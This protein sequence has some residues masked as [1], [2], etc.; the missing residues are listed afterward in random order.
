MLLRTVSLNRM[1]SWVTLPISLRSES[2]LRS[3]TSWPSTSRRPPVTSKKRGMRFTRVVLPAPL[4][5]TNATTSPRGTTRLMPRQDFFLALFR[6]RRR[7]AHSRSGSRCGIPS[8]PSRAAGRA[9]SSCSSMNSKDVA[10]RAQRLLEAVVEERELAHRIVELED[11]HDEGEEG[12]LGERS[13]AD[14]D[15]GP[16]AAAARSRPRR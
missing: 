2:I 9:R 15:R 10:R 6:L 14:S 12:R 4:G 16:P 11:G 3:R 13:V 1:V 8:R 5:P 7:S